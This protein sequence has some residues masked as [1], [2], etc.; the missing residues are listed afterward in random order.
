MKHSLLCLFCFAIAAAAASATVLPVQ[1]SH[2]PAVNQHGQMV[3]LDETI[4]PVPDRCDFAC[5]D[6]DIEVCAHNGQCL[7]MFTS[8]CT[9]AAY[10]CRN[11]H[12]RFNIVENYRC[13][14]GYQPLCSKAEQRELRLTL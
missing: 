12:K 5:T 13:T 4:H 3:W 10:N 11:P 8:R 14:Q 9:M 2:L 6:H 7:Q 1:R